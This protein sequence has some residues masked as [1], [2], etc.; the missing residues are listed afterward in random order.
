MKTVESSSSETITAQVSF[1][2]LFYNAVI[3][4]WYHAVGDTAEE[5]AIRAAKLYQEDYFNN[6]EENDE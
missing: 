6:I 3:F 5:A 1:D 2:G 4:G